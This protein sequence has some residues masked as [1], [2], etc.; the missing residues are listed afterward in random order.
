MEV[1]GSYAE[2]GYALIRDLIGPGIAK[3]F[4]HRLAR[5]LGRTALP[6][7]GEDARPDVLNR[8]ALNVF[9]PDY[10]PM[11]F[12]LWGLT[13][14]IGRLVGR[15]LLPTYDYFRVYRAGDVCRVHSDREACEHSLSLTLGY[16]D[17]KAWD[18]EIGSRVLPGPRTFVT[19]DFADEAH[20]SVAMAAGD[21]VLYRGVHRRHGRTTPNPNRWSAHLFLHWVEADGPYR[22]QAFQGAEPMSGEVNFG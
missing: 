18:L 17:G 7:R 6:L 20:A 15:E 2:D 1:A 19:D 21:A 9:G 14:L 10:A 8:P 16:S 12:F 11:Q 13:P 3:A 22:D 5:D 4:L